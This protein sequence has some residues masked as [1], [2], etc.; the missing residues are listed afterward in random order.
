[1]RRRAGLGLAFALVLAAGCERMDPAP[2]GGAPEPA[3]AAPKTVTAPDFSLP[4][5]A[6][7]QLALADLRGRP[8][9]ID[10]WATWCAPCE[11]QVPVLNAFHEKHGEHIPVLGIAVDADPNAVPSFVAEHD[12]RYRV[13][14]G[15][16]G[17]ARDFGALGFPT[18]YV[19]RPDGSVHSSHVGVVTPEALEAAVAEWTGAAG[20]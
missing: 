13:L 3:P 6:G 14:L 9:V 18:L 1:V 20:S 5:L 8:V 7:G 19:V 16:E 2:A 12:V 11:R 15:D 10:F 17:L 4:D